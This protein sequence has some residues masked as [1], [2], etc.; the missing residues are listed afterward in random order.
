MLVIDDIIVSDDLYLVRFCC[1]LPKCH[2]ACCVEGD[3]G[4]PLTEEEI[5]LLEDHIDDIKPFM[6]LHGM[7]AISWQGVFDYDAFGAFVTP[8][9]QDTECVYCNFDEEDVAYCAI[10]RAFEE[11]MISFEKPVSCH[12][13][14]VRI[15]QYDNF[16]AVNYHK[17]FICKPALKQGK[18]EGLM[19]YQFLKPALTR[20]YGEEW[21]TK[22]DSAVM[23]RLQEQR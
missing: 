3:A 20:K 2:G 19:L 7:D 17:W 14:P 13:Y 21:F 6:T 8:L 12:L 23:E 5:S 11:G 16:E 9:V 1:P 4:A 10:Q 15:S 18:K 22:L